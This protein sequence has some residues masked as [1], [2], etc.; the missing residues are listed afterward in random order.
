MLIPQKKS[1]YALRAIYELAKRVG[2]GPIKIS[3]IAVAQAIPRRFLE[4]I[5]NQLKGSGLVES[6]RGFYGGYTLVIPPD[7]I[8]VGDVFRY[9]QKEKDQNRPSCIACVSQ[10]ACPFLDRCAFSSLWQE[11]KSAAFE[12]YDA[13]TMQDLLEANESAEAVEHLKSV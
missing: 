12:I 11:V 10:E 8:S 9:L 1:Q 3:E 6:K 7:Q 2:Q 4:V 5:L 13:T